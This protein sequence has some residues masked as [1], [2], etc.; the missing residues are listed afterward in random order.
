MTDAPE[1]VGLCFRC[2]HAR[3]VRTPRSVFWRCA[4]AEWDPRFERYPRLPVVAC[5]GFEAGPRP[6]ADEPGEPPDPS[7]SP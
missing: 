5:I 3:I 1:R 7:A 4:R 6:G 2:M